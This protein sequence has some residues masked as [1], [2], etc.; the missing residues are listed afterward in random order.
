M[1]QS[2]SS[3]LTV[4]RF[5]V[6]AQYTIQSMGYIRYTSPWTHFPRCCDE[7]ILYFIESGDLYVEEDGVQWHA[8]E[9]TALLLEPGKEH[10]GYQSSVVSYYYIH[11][12]CS[13]PLTSGILTEE[14]REQIITLHMNF[15]NAAWGDYQWHPSPYDSVP[16]HFPKLSNL[17]GSYDFFRSLR[18]ANHIFFESFEGRR[19]LVALRLQEILT[20]ICRELVHSCINPSSTRI[21]VLIR[22]IRYYIDHNYASPVTSR[23][24]SREFHINY[25]YANRQFKRYTGQSIHGYLTSVRM[26]RAKRLLSSKVSVSQAA[27]LV[28]IDDVAYFSRLFKKQTG[29]SPSE[30]AQNTDYISRER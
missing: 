26:H 11:F 30:Y 22:D 14:L 3:P 21:L 13:E 5:P 12:T 7:Y 6:T 15:L 16:L 17:G 4:I 10:R 23:D 27:A 19:T 2:H 20:M 9:N 25:D 18:E 24:I 8:G 28:G 1:N 29:V